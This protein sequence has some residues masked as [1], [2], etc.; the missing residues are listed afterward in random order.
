[1]FYHYT[2][3]TSRNLLWSRFNSERAECL[4][5]YQGTCRIAGQFYVVS[6]FAFFAGKA[7]VI[8]LKNSKIV[9]L[10]ESSQM[11]VLVTTITDKYNHPR[12]GLFCVS[13]MATMWEAH[14]NHVCTCYSTICDY[15]C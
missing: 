6:N 5:S 11:H 4:D 1:M 9:T 2:Q 15:S 12:I 14:D 8:K 7:S 10:H 3:C 13:K